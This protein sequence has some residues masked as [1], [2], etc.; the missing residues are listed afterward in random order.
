ME[1]NCCGL[2]AAPVLFRGRLGNEGEALSLGEKG[3]QE[4]KIV[5]VLFI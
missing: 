5:V 1:R 3:G 2:T 4:M